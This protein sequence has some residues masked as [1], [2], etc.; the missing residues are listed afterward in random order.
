MADNDQSGRKPGSFTD[1]PIIFNNPFDSV[2]GHFT[3]ENNLTSKT[4]GIKFMHYMCVADPILQNQQG[5][6]RHSFGYDDG[7]QQFLDDPRFHREN[8][9]LY[10]KKGMIYGIFQGNSKDFKD[11]KAG[12][13]SDS[14]AMVT[15]NRYYADSNEYVKVCEYDK[16]IPCEIT[17]EFFSVNFQKFTHNPTGI[18]RLQYPVSDVLYLIDSD[19]VTYNVGSDYIVENGYLKWIDGG[20]RPGLN[21]QTHKGKVCGIRYT[22]RPYFYISRCLHDIR[23]RPEIQADGSLQT[24]AG[25]ITVQVVAE[26]IFLDSRN[27]SNDDPTAQL[28]EGDGGNV[29]PR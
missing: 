3:A 16:L 15:L 17:K 28:D 2:H 20:N 13:Y 25:P 27:N 23:V 24:K 18:D 29:G 14:G 11:I 5:D 1:V 6:V 4:F 22:Y 7:Y 10:I 21:N 12:L 9:F 8:E 26:W 19:G